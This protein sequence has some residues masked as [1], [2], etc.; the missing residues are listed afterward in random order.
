MWAFLAAVAAAVQA[1]AAII[2]L[3]LQI[4][5]HRRAAITESPSL[6]VVVVAGAI[7]APTAGERA[8]L[9]ADGLRSSITGRGA[10]T[11]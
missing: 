2:V 5:L 3:A 1:L 11:A 4:S 9:C 6:A 10:E 7:E 8:P